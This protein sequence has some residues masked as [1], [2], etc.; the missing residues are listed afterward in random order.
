LGPVAGLHAKF[1]S[2]VSDG[3]FGGTQGGTLGYVAEEKYLWLCTLHKF[4]QIAGGRGNLMSTATFGAR[5]E[6]GY[7]RL[8]GSLLGRAQVL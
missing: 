3:Y 5:A 7:G 6:A 1:N 4:M 2:E 8:P